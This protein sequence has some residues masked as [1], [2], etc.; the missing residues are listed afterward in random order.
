MIDLSKI[1][2]RAPEGFSKDKAKKEFKEL[3]E[4]IAEMQERMYAEKKHSL[5]VI[6]QGMDSSGKDGTTKRVFR[7]CM[8]IG[9]KVKGYGKPTEEEL[10]HD[11]LWRVHQHTPKKGMIQVFV[12]SHYE[13]ILIQRV[14]HWINKERVEKRIKAI[15]AFE[16]L[17]TFDNNTTIIKCYLH[18][19]PERQQ[20]KLQERIDRPD[21]QWKHNAN[22]WKE[23]KLW[24]EY[25][26]A[27]HDV[28][29]RC[30]AIPWHVVPADQRW[31]RNYYAAKIV[32]ETLERLNPKYPILTA[33]ELKVER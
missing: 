18:L 5:L 9:L 32:A 19:S 7:Q 2:T 28:L 6:F 31:Y 23:A 1:S 25:R 11:F 26:D 15:N 13:D 20:E 17:L 21:K 4:Y 12:R 30:N 10:G 14:H 22:D 8:P 16:E 29:N 24:D 27:Y 3:Q 33:E